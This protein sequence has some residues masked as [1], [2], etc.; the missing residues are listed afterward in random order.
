MSKDKTSPPPTRSVLRE[1]QLDV[2]GYSVFLEG[3]QTDRVTTLTP[4]F[5]PNIAKSWEAVQ[6]IKTKDGTK[7]TLAALS[8]PT[9]FPKNAVY[10]PAI[11]R[12]I[13]STGTEL[14]TPSSDRQLQLSYT[15]PKEHRNRYSFYG[16]VL[17]LHYTA[18]VHCLAW[19]KAPYWFDSTKRPIID[20]GFDDQTVSALT[21]SSEERR[22]SSEYQDQ[23]LYSASDKM[24]SIW[25]ELECTPCQHGGRECAV[26]MVLP[27][28]G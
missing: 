13:E 5:G 15:I 25:A 24:T 3:G 14:F 16:R 2:F 19:P 28:G 27:D 10:L 26:T 21:R 1:V 9:L 7:T 12:V 8:P 17:P 22:K 11:T 18:I 6:V 20:P 23:L 4:G